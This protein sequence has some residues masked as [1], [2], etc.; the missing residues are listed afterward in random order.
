[1]TTLVGIAYTAP[2]IA[3]M[4]LDRELFRAFV[5]E[6]RPGELHAFL[7]STDDRHSVVL[8]RSISELVRV[9]N[10]AG[11]GA[12]LLFDEP[13]VMAEIEG[14]NLIDSEKDGIVFAKRQISV[15]ELNAALLQPGEFTVPEDLRSSVQRLSQSIS[16][17]QLLDGIEPYEKDLPTEWYTTVCSYLA[18]QLQ[19]RSW[20][21]RGQKP[22]LSASVPVEKI[23]EIEKFIQDAPSGEMLWRAYYDHVENDVPV[24]DVCAQYECPAADLAYMVKRLGSKKGHKYYRSPMDKPMVIKKKRKVRKKKSKKATKEKAHTP[25][26]KAK[27][28]DEAPAHPILAHVREV[29]QATKSHDFVRHV[30]A[31]VVGLTSKR[32]FTFACKRAVKGGGSED[33]VAAV[34]DFVESDTEGLV[35]PVRAAFCHYSYH[36]GVKPKDAAEKYGASTWLFK[37]VLAAKPLA[38]VATWADWPEEVAK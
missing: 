36:R 18:G 13:S 34:Q 29:T 25:S 9:Q 23:A 5:Y 2:E 20:V 26:K 22:A 12:F 33:L 7:Q 16:L 27:T 6:G 4:S 38:Y 15:A 21:A 11:V 1:M 3:V 35:G 31:R 28:A 30:A 24:D 14:I 19:K 8:L 10:V 32:S 17:V 37:L